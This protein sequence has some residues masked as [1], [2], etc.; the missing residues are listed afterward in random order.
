[1]INKL[2]L[3]VSFKKINVFKACHIKFLLNVNPFMSI[4]EAV[5]KNIYYAYIL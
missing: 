4:R 1:M 2:Y 3:F 5:T